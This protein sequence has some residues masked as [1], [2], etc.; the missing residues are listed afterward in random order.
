M[1]G[2]NMKP[3]QHNK[4]KKHPLSMAICG[5]LI[6]QPLITPMVFAQD[7]QSQA[8]IDKDLESIVVY[9]RKRGEG[10]KDI[11]VSV[12]AISN[13]HLA[14]AGVTDISEMFALMPGVENNAAGSRIS[15]K[16]AIRGVGSNENASIR[17]KVTTFIDGIPV[18]G[19]QGISSFAGLDHAEVLRGPQSAAFGRSTFGGAINYITRDPL[20]D[21]KF[22]LD[23]RG[24]L[25]A[26]E[27]RNLSLTMTTPLVEDKLAVAVTL[28]TKNYGGA[29]EWVTT[30]GDQLGATNDKL[31]SIKLVYTPTDNIK[32]EL[33]Y[34]TQKI[35]DG[36]PVVTFANL[37]QLEPHPLDQDGLCVVNGGG[38]DC[39][40]IGAIDSV[41]LVFD[42]NF[43]LEDNPILD[44]GTRIKRDRLQG[45]IDVTLDS[46]LTLTA[47]GAITD[48]VGDDWLDK[49][50]Y[51]SLSTN[52]ISSSPESDEKY[53]EVRL[54]SASDRTFTWL[55]GASIYKYDYLNTVYVNRTAG[56][57]ADFFAESAKNVGLFFS[58]GYDFTD[59]FTGSFEGRYQSDK[60]SSTYPANEERGVANDLSVESD[61]KSFQPRLA[62]SYELND[63]HNL[64]MQIARGS[65]PAGFN[66]NTL[67]PILLATAN[68]ENF[69]LASFLTFDEEVITSY[70]FGIKGLLSEPKLRYALATYYIDWTGYVEG[71]PT[72]WDPDDGVLLDGVTADDY[73]ARLFLNTGD[74]EGFGVELE[75]Q[76]MPIE[77]FELGFSLAYSG[78]EFTDDTCS[79]IAVSYD[80]P[81]TST[82]PYACATVVGGN[83]PAMISKYT[84]ALNGT[85]TVPISSDLDGYAR[86]DY[87]YRSKRYV[88]QTNMDYLPGYSMVNV[89]AGVKSYE[90]SL[91][92]YVN[93]LFNE[94]SPAGAE[95][96]YDGRLAGSSFN[97]AVRLR[98][99]RT[100]GINLTYSFF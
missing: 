9:A 89:R 91:E 68:E 5:L 7:E 20:T 27:T 74:L 88:E 18:V 50:A 14:N 73:F 95:R 59:K 12:S 35:D 64:Y 54:A 72:T 56:V 65:N 79:P 6:S 60:I 29:D 17:A 21:G 76:W 66:I 58:V 16:P 67:D 8:V 23:L 98:Q 61:T 40:I 2:D 70:E 94:D 39:V 85:Y 96:F 78:L 90:W 99:P 22:E 82:S 43:D 10:I 19:S 45:S 44:P 13:E 53:A 62:L 81:A 30:S 71:T 26:D 86:I 33:M 47:L 28:E 77:E 83:Q 92:L 63:E 75:G 31:G 34:L 36:H 69:N 4:L 84:T 57:L 93:N 97:T 38:T 11:P 49:D 24:T 3:V 41:P 55:V 100:A 52:H 80:I 51:S 46:G 87:Q 1:L 32:A 15:S 48:E 37:D 25:G 42:Y